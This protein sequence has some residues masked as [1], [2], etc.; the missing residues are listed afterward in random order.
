MLGGDFFEE[1]DEEQDSLKQALL[2]T[3]PILLGNFNI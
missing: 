1:S 3:S 2:E